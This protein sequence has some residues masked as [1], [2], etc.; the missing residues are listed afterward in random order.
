MQQYKCSDHLTGGR[1]VGGDRRH[2]SYACCLPE[3]RS[4]AERRSG[5]DRRH[6]NRIAA[7]MVPANEIATT[8]SKRS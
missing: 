2:Y 5:K 6:Q 4:G 8:L 7:M 3:R 1:R